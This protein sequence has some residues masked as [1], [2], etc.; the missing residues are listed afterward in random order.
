MI[1][2]R[3]DYTQLKVDSPL[4]RR[5]HYFVN[6]TVKNRQSQT[7]MPANESQSQ[8]KTAAAAAPAASLPVAVATYLRDLF[9][10]RE[11]NEF[12]LCYYE[13]RKVALCAHLLKTK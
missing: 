10:E 3:G 4:V 2:T 12:D 9:R 5:C 6:E 7:K 8:Q 13:T 1:E 11:R